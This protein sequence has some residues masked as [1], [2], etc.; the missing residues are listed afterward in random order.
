MPKVLMVLTSHSTLG[1]T[2]RSTGF[3]VGEAAH[4]HEVF[5]REGIEVVFTSP[6]G[7]VAPQDGVNRADPSQAAFLD[8]A[9][10]AQALSSTLAPAEVTAA[11]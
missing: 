4:P 10:I 6:R 9:A 11:D 5:T 8:D 3:Y 7:G 1:S 2:G